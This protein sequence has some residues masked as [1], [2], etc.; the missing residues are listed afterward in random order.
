[1]QAEIISV[2]TEVL[3][4]EILDTNAQ[5][6]STRLKDIGIDVYRR[7]TI[8]DNKKR[9]KACFAEA[10]SRADVVIA[11]GGLGPTDDD[12]TAECLASAIGKNVS[13]NAAA[14]EHMMNWFSRWGRQP[15]DV[16]KKQAFV[17]EEGNFFPNDSGTAPGQYVFVD[18]KLCVILPGPPREMT[19]MFENSVIPLIKKTFPNLIPLF[20]TNL[21]LIG[22]PE[23]KVGEVVRDLMESS[24]PTLAP[25]AGSWEVRLRIAARGKSVE[26]SKELVA[27]MERKVRER[28]NDYIWGE[29]L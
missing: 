27:G 22:L 28:L 13:F 5:Y 11:T 26:E 25:Y 19:P 23:A 1:M 6:I 16:E 3:L 24:N 14:W 20:T 21:K 29:R 2:G 9:L 7:V 12:I 18:G 4:G 15:G 17:I 8:G 10:L